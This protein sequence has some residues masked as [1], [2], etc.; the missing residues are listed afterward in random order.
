MAKKAKYII[1]LVGAGG[2]GGGLPG[3]N[4]VLA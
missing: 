1:I 3:K 2:G 4:R